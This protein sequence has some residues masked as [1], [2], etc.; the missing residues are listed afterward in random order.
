M[1]SPPRWSPNSFAPP[2]P[3]PRT[4]RRW[5]G[6]TPASAPVEPG[7]GH[8]DRRAGGLAGREVA[9]GLDGIGQGIALVH[10]NPDLAARHHLEEILGIG[11]QIGIPGDIGP[12]R[13]AGDVERAL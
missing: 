6:S 2:A 1:P 5:P 13:R 9:M 7:L 12:K 4:G 10:L 3:A 11:L 8:E